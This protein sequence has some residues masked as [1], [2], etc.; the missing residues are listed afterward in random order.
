M[1]LDGGL[2][3][4]DQPLIDALREDFEQLGDGIGRDR[5]CALAVTRWPDRVIQRLRRNGFVIEAVEDRF[6][7]YSEPTS[8]EAPGSP[9]APV[10][11]GSPSPGASVDAAPTLFDR[12]AA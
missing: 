11:L 5:V 1:T 6:K 3:L 10:P 12:R 9:P 7:L 2:M 8:I 4:R